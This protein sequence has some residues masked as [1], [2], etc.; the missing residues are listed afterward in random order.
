MIRD[1]KSISKDDCLLFC[2]HSWAIS[3]SVF[4]LFSLKSRTLYTW[5]FQLNLP[6]TEQTLQY[7]EDIPSPLPQWTVSPSPTTTTKKSL[8][9]CPPEFSE[10]IHSIPVHDFVSVSASQTLMCKRTTR[11][12]AGMKIPIWQVLI[13]SPDNP[14]AAWPWEV[15]INTWIQVKY[16]FISF[17]KLQS[18]QSFQSFLLNTFQIDFLLSSPLFSRLVWTITVSFIF[19]SRL[20]LAQPTERGQGYFLT[21]S[22]IMKCTFW[23]SIWA[24]SSEYSAR[25]SVSSLLFHHSWNAPL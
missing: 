22:M 23:I 20:T 19:L 9:Y 13:T 10:T 15:G 18:P 7:F 3:N 8:V 2:L 12:P 5:L 24:N 16:C 25:T 11:N 1:P 14:G 4:P 6:Q 17:P 21:R